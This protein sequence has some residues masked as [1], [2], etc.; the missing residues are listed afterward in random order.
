MRPALLLRLSGCTEFI[1]EPF[2]HQG[3]CPGQGFGYGGKHLLILTDDS[4][5]FRWK[6]LVFLIGFRIGY[7]RLIFLPTPSADEFNPHSVALEFQ[8]SSPPLPAAAH[9]NERSPQFKRKVFLCYF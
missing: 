3:M 6:A 4:L 5:N 1:D 2:L 8:S 7:G 9:L